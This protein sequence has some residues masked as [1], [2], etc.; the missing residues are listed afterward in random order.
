VYSFKEFTYKKDNPYG[1]ELI[2]SGGVAGHM[3][4]LYDNREL[5]FTKLKEILAAASEGRLE[6][7]EKTDGQNLFIS[8][9]VKD[10]KA[11]A[12][13][14]KGN[15]KQ[16]GMTAEELATKFAG[17]GDLERAFVDAFR[18]FERAVRSL[19]PQQQEKIFGPD[20]N[21]YYNAEIMDPR[22][23]NVVNYDKKTLLIHQ[24]GHAY[25]D[26]ETG[27]VADIDITGNAEALDS[28]LSQMQDATADDE[29]HVAKNAIKKL[30]ALDDDAALN[31]TLTNIESIQNRFGLSDNNTIGDYLEVNVKQYIDKI[32]PQGALHPDVETLLIKKVMGEKGYNINSL[33]KDLDPATKQ[34]VKEINNKSS[35]IIKSAIYPLE[36]VIHDFAVTMLGTLASAFI[37]DN[38]KEVKRLQADVSKAIKAIEASGNEIAHQVLKQQLQKLKKIE[39]IKT[40]TEGFVFNYDGQAYKFTGNFAPANQLLG[41]F[42]YGRAGVPPMQME[43]QRQFE[44][45]VSE[46]IKVNEARKPFDP[47]EFNMIP[48]NRPVS[49]IIGRFNPWTKGHNSM[50][51]NAK[52]PVVIGLVKSP[53]TSLD[54]ER[55][56]FDFD[57]QKEIINRSN[58]PKIEDVVEFS[59]ANVP[60]II[61]ELREMGYEPKELWAGTDRAPAYQNQIN[62]YPPQINS[63][64]KLKIL[65]RNEDDPGIAGISATKVRQAIKVG[66][67]N[68]IS[69]TMEGIDQNLFKIMQQKMLIS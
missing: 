30:Q 6:G 35:E 64:L 27:D 41:L 12:A 33:T 62:L 1:D 53:K 3:A 65:E 59:A 32:I 44:E 2:L 47:R 16:G 8:Y 14:N 56:P 5:T 50:T 61:S 38:R 60:Q 52:Y 9:S 17:R 31:Q 36:D 34:T 23:S 51:E 21:V 11:K 55:N 19:S 18:T 20:A 37:I 24:V 15:I 54:K 4:H 48:A 66:D 69:R 43:E 40:A 22:T 28:A 10:G 26:K 49:L 45:I 67:Y 7:T 25:F 57:L 46:A 63:K 29:Y 58:N 68:T 39:N 42:K 13:R